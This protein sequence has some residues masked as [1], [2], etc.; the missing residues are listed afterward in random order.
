MKT[1]LEIKKPVLDLRGQPCLVAKDKEL[2][3]QEALIC[4]VGAF[5]CEP[6]KAARV[7]K[8]GTDLVKADGELQLEDAELS[9]LKEAVEQNG[10][11][12][13]AYVIAQMQEAL[14]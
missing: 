14:K 7:W 2:T 10:F 6:A 3:L 8:V 1:L 5:K 11:G 13:F 9:L 4:E 12:F